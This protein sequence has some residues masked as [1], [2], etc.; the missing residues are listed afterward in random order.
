MGNCAVPCS[1]D[2]ARQKIVLLSNI[3]DDPEF[4]HGVELFRQQNY[5]SALIKA[6]HLLNKKEK[7]MYLELYNSAIEL[8]HEYNF[9]E[10]DYYAVFDFYR[11]PSKVKYKYYDFI[12]HDK[13]AF[14]EGVYSN[15]FVSALVEKE[16]KKNNMLAQFCVA[17][18][19]YFE[20]INLMQAMDM[21][22]SLSE[23]RFHRAYLYYAEMLYGLGQKG[24]AVRFYKESADYGYQ[25]A[26]YKLAKILLEGD[27][28]L[29]N[30]HDAIRYYFLSINGKHR[31]GCYWQKFDHAIFQTAILDIFEEN[32]RIKKRMSDL[33]IDECVVFDGQSICRKPVE[34]S[35]ESIGLKID[36]TEG[37][38][39]EPLSPPSTVSIDGVVESIPQVKVDKEKEPE[40]KEQKTEH[41]TIADHLK[42]IKKGRTSPMSRISEESDLGEDE[43]DTTNARL[44]D[45]EDSDYDIV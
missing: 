13:L 18:K 32:A 45:D 35:I 29:K 23:R 3:T 27:G 15:A 33:N 12:W 24:E 34:K 20:G 31:Q 8:M 2:E 14:F 28:V 26:Q 36:P 25:V 4:N 30:C 37:L 9:N 43:H 10:K 21:F 40:S 6:V 11:D 22:K 44:I 17:F 16:L 38:R 42:D 5:I 1:H 39:D 41:L 7:P 19:N